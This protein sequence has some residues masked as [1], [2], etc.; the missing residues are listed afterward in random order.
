MGTMG[1]P[2]DPRKHQRETERNLLIGAAAIILV[3]GGGLIFLLYGRGSGITGTICLGG[4]V[5][6]LA[7]L[8]GVVKL[9]EHF[10][11]E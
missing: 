6:I 5:A 3:V 11:G 8:Y 2:T 7:L 10:G 9:F 1:E 4:A